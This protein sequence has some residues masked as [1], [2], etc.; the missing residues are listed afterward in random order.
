ML[1]TKAMERISGGGALILKWRGFQMKPCD[2]TES[3]TTL[4][5]PPGQ[6]DVVPLKVHRSEDQVLSKW[7]ASWRERLSILIFGTVWFYARGRTHPP[8]AID[9]RRTVF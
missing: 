5:P 7:K 2:F 1:Y 9:A 4:K 8:I 3:N 6:P